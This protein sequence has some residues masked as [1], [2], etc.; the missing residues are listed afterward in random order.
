MR[1]YYL[2]IFQT[3]R[4]KIFNICLPN[5]KILEGATAAIDEYTEIYL[6]SQVP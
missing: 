6:I 2:S 1:G 3:K 5:Y 4:H